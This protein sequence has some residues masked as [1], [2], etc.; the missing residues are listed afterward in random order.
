MRT[1][2]IYFSRDR[3]IGFGVVARRQEIRNKTPI[4]WRR[5]GTS[6]DIEK[7]VGGAREGAEKPSGNAAGN[8]TSR[9]P[10]AQSALSACDVSGD[11]SYPCAH[12]LRRWRH[13]SRP[14]GAQ[15]NRVL[16][17]LSAEK[18]RGDT[19]SPQINRVN[20]GISAKV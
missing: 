8:A 2:E 18:R 13:R 1:L 9:K 14:N 10:E 17:Y 4:R 6:N 11:M 7:S 5:R 15:K 12:F 20:R 16:A 19:I 3:E